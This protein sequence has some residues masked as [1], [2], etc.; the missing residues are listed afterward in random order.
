MQND[1]S[2]QW[3][4]KI[5]CE[6]PELVLFSNVVAWAELRVAT[7]MLGCPGKC[8]AYTG[9]C[10]GQRFSPISSQRRVLDQETLALT[11]GCFVGLC[12]FGF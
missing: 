6:T 2:S 7:C 4:M 1:C 12:C 9:M 10:Q 11:L 3:Q 8:Y 5:T